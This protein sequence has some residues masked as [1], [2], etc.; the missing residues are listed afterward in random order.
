[1]ERLKKAQRTALL[2]WIA[3]GLETPEINERAARFT[4]PFQVKPSLVN[5]YRSTRKAAIAD[6]LSEQQRQALTTGLARRE[7]RITRLARIA[8]LVE[9]DLLKSLWLTDAKGVNGEMVYVEKPNSVMLAE[10]RAYLAQ[11]AT[12]TSDADMEARLTR[13]E[14]IA[15]GKRSTL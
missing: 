11:I 3:E 13:L 4:P 2:E 12:E 1:M 15:A 6:I 5:H 9:G 8:E 7:E 14:E 10:F